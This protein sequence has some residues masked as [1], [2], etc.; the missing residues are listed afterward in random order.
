MNIGVYS[1][2]TSFPIVYRHISY[3]RI[4]VDVFGRPWHIERGSWREVQ[5]HSKSGRVADIL[6][7]FL[8][9]LL[10]CYRNIRVVEQIEWV[11]MD[12]AR[13]KKGGGLWRDML[14]S[15]KNYQWMENFL[16][17][18]YLKFTLEHPFS[19]ET[20]F[21]LFTESKVCILATNTQLQHNTS[22]QTQVIERKPFIF[23]VWQ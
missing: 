19:R 18:F 8:D 7:I 22:S 11:I 4:V 6:Q 3:T 5:A 15:L 16:L 10:S 12:L 9:A 20:T 2:F 17:R 1:T 21:S 23:F 14:T 13:L